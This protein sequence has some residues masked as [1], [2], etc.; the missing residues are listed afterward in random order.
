MTGAYFRQKIICDLQ[1]V[2]SEVSLMLSRYGDRNAIE[3]REETENSR[4]VEAKFR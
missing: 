2:Q 1:G 4:G 3:E